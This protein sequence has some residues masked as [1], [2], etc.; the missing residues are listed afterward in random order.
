MSID[1]AKQKLFSGLVERAIVSSRQIISLLETEFDALTG[2]KP[3]ILDSIIN[4]K[5]QHLIKISQIMAEQEALLSS[6]H[7]SND[8]NGVEILYANLPDSHPWRQSWSKLKQLAKTLAESNLRNG[9]LLSQRTETT[10]KSLDILTGH[11]SSP[12]VYKYGGKTESV[13]QSKSLAYA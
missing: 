8:K 7:L 12:A 6:L 9:I 11:Q 13:R 10:R 2:S 4:E 3:E 1:T 5:K